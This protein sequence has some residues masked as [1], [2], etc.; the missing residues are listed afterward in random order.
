MRLTIG[1]CDFDLQKWVYNESPK[2]DL[3]LSNFTEL[4]AVD[5]ERVK[6]IHRIKELTNRDNLKIIGA[7]WTSPTW[8]KIVNE[9]HGNTRIQPKYYQLWSEYYLRFVQMYS[10]YVAQLQ[11]IEWDIVAIAKCC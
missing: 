9:W 2:N 6:Y 11:M 10:T 1:G 4:N 5:I 8:M 3:T 7:A